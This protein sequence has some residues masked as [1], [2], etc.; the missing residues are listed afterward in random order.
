M[1]VC[2]VDAQPVGYCI[3]PGEVTILG[4]DTVCAE[5]VEAY[6][7]GEVPKGFYP[8]W[9]ATNGY[10]E[11]GAGTVFATRWWP[12]GVCTLACRLVCK[13]DT[14]VHTD[15]VKQT[16]FRNS[17]LPIQVLGAKQV[18]GDDTATYRLSMEADQVVWSISPAELGSVAQGQY[19]QSATIVWNRQAQPKAVAAQ[20]LAKVTHCGQTRTI[21]QDVSIRTTPT[22][23][24]IASAG[25]NEKNDLLGFIAKPLGSRYD[26]DFGDGT[27][28]TTTSNLCEHRYPTD[29]TFAAT[30]TVH[31]PEGC[32]SSV[33]AATTLQVWP[34]A[35]VGLSSPNPRLGKKP[36]QLITTMP[37]IIDSQFVYLLY[38][39]DKQVAQNNSGFFE[40]RKAGAYTIEINLQGMPRPWWSRPL[41]VTKAEKKVSLD[42]KLSL[43]VTNNQ[44]GEVS[45]N[46]TVGAGV[47]LDSV[48]VHDPD[49]GAIGVNDY[50]HHAQLFEGR[51]LPP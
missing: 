8:E 33:M 7:V 4:A 18:C 9:R 6:S 36:V 11:R 38:R 47:R 37:N 3:K 51:A 39:N 48:V 30:V 35:L 46:A 40:V 1:M 12:Y 10:P 20:V 31:Q 34:T 16:I 41:L 2:V 19:T 27:K 50:Q 28:L 5:A 21:R 43:T 42:Q 29:G 32:A 23:E 44:C 25:W 14:S 24:M 17:D 22:L 26:W 13:Y 45:A 15:W 49:A